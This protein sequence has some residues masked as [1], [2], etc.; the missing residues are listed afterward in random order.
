MELLWPRGTY[1]SYGLTQAILVSKIGLI[2]VFVIFK[3]LSD[4]KENVEQ[5]HACLSG[6][7]S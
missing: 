5:C 2:V 3:Q 7:F 4:N 6:H 1:V